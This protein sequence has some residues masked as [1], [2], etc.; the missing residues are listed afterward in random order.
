MPLLKEH[1]RT[2][3]RSIASFAT[4]T[5]LETLWPTRCAVCDAPGDVLCPACR[6]ALMFVDVNHACPVCGAPFGQHQCTECNETMLAAAEMN[7]LPVDA[8]ASALLADDAARR[9][10]TVYKDANER[11]LASEIAAI[12]MRYLPPEWRNAYLTYIP[13]TTDA[14]RRRGFDH[15]ELV[16]RAAVKQ[17]G[18]QGGPLFKRP[19]SLDQRNLG[20]HDRQQNMS[21]R[22]A[23]RPNV[24]VPKRIVVLDDICTTGAT[25][26]AAANCLRVDGA[27]EIY[28]LTFAKVLA[29]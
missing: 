25:L 19:Q 16:A 14:L 6:H 28:G 2:C 23:L 20:R 27:H 5:A 21:E 22:F 4:E 24:S 29:T 3:L 9:I 26:F 12:T 17:T 15:T 1:T 8:M 11:R 10:V 7:A 13:A 18:M